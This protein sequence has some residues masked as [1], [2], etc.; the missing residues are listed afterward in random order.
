MRLAGSSETYSDR[1][2]VEGNLTPYARY[3][4]LGQSMLG[5][6]TEDGQQTALWTPTLDADPWQAILDPA[7][8]AQVRSAVEILDRRQ[9]PAFVLLPIAV[10]VPPA[11]GK[12]P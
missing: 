8:A 3:F 4:R 7:Q 5:Y 6:V 2:S 10:T 12:T 11:E 9:A 1:A